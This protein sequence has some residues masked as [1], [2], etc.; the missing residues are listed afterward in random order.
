MNH[1]RRRRNNQRVKNILQT[2]FK[3]TK[4]YTDLLNNEKYWRNNGQYF[5]AKNYE[6]RSRLLLNGDIKGAQ[7]PV[8][9]E[10]L[11]CPTKKLNYN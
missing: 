9:T 8:K 5:I 3:M 1:A 10:T 6:I 4:L 11:Y 2:D 7:V